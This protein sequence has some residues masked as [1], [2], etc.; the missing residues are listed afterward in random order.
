MN[1]LS[2]I[3]A[4]QFGTLQQRLLTDG[5]QISISSGVVRSTLCVA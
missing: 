5:C 4:G 3:M 1:E 2:S